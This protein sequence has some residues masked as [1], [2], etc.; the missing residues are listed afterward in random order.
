MHP[1]TVIPM[2]RFP[3]NENTTMMTVTSTTIFVRGSSPVR[4]VF[5]LPAPLGPQ[6]NVSS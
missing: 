6:R 1:A 2:T 5:T 3:G 4:A